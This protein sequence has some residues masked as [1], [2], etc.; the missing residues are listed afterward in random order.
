MRSN[1]IVLMVSLVLTVALL[2]L[3]V[4]DI[5]YVQSNSMRPL[6]SKGDRLFI[7]QSAYSLRLPWR[8]TPL[9]TWDIPNRGDI[10]VFDNPH[11]D[12]QLPWLKRVIGLPGDKLH[13]HNH[14]LYLNGEVISGFDNSNVEII[15]SS[16]DSQGRYHIWSSYLEE[17]WGPITVPRNS[18]FLLGDHRSASTDSR[19]WGTIPLY[20]LRGKASFRVWPWERISLY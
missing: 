2:R 13:F 4:V 9:M 20:R 6:I 11:D 16:S 10:V 12:D 14:Q 19:V 1:Q 15:P 3:S 7:H 8:T 18:L 5:V 17:D